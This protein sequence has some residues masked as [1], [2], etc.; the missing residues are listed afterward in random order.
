MQIPARPSTPAGNQAKHPSELPEWAVHKMT[1]RRGSRYAY[2]EIDPKKTALIVIDVMQD[3]LENTPTVASIILPISHLADALRSKGGTVAWVSPAPMDK[4]NPNLQTLWGAQHYSAIAT[5]TCAQTISEKPDFATGLNPDEGHDLFAQKNSYSAFF[6]GQCDLPEQLNGRGID[7]VV[8]TG[9]LTNICCES[10]ARDAAA[11]GYRVIQIA[12][13][14]AARTD[15]EH[16]MALYN[17]F[18]NFG[19]VRLTADFLEALGEG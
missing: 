2:T 6:P 18:R 9:A 5:A 7:T 10:S 3:Y 11:R 8:I 14:N 17:I 13:A 19:D 12:D 15:E 16:L 4:H 1:Q